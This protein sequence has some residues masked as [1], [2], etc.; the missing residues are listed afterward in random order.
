[1]RAGVQDFF[2]GFFAAGFVVGRPLSTALVATVFAAVLRD[3]PF[4][5]NLAAWGAVVIAIIYGAL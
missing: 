5:V 3:W 4:L 2:G 1:M